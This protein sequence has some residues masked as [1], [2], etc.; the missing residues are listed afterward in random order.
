MRDRETGTWWQQVTGK[1]IF[2]PLKGRSL[3]FL[4]SDELTFGLWKSEAPAGQV[5]APVTAYAK[6]Y[7]SDWEPKVAKMKVVV[8]F[9]ENGMKDRD[10]VMGLDV[11]DAARAYPADTI[12]KQSPIEDRVGG[13]PVVV[14]VGPDGKSIRAFISRLDGA[15]LELFKKTA[16][17]DWGLIDSSGSEWNFRGCAVSG[18]AAGKCLEPVPVLKDYWF[19]WR[20][21]HPNTTIYHH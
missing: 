11:N 13:T 5:L 7:D 20:N 17:S 14:M 16:T 9:P 15:D 19:D 4:S 21:Y 12:L 1:A 18:P 6:E 2:G 3:D 10:V 8:S